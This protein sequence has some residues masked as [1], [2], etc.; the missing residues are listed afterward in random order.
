[1]SAG[2]EIAL[3]GES[4][5]V[6][7]LRSLLGKRVPFAESKRG[8]FGWL[9]QAVAENE[10]EHTKLVAS[11]MHRTA[12]E[13]GSFS[14]GTSTAWQSGEAGWISVPTLANELGLSAT[15][16][17]RLSETMGFHKRQF[18]VARARYRA[19]SPKQTEMMRQALRSSLSRSEAAAALGVSRDTFNAFVAA[20]YIAIFARPGVGLN[21]DR[22][23]SEDVAAL[24]VRLLRDTELISEMPDRYLRLAD[25]R[26]TCK[27]DPALS[28]KECL[29]R[30][31]PLRWRVGPTAGDVLI[32]NPH[33]ASPDNMEAARAALHTL[34]GLSFYQAATIL[35][36]N[37]GVIEGLVEMKQ[38]RMCSETRGWRRIDPATVEAFGLRYASPEIYSGQGDCRTKIGQLGSKLVKLGI[39]NLLVERSDGSR[40]YVIDRSSAATVL[41]LAHDPDDPDIDGLVPLEAEMLRAIGALGNFKLVGRARGI[42]L[43]S[44]AGQLTIR[45]RFRPEQSAIEVVL[46][47]GA[48]SKKNIESILFRENGLQL[49]EVDGRFE[50][51]D[52]I[53]A[54]TLTSASMRSILVARILAATERLRSTFSFMRNT[55]SPSDGLHVQT[56]EL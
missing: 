46:T 7:L 11:L 15:A 55:R 40:S 34:P 2:F 31:M 32:A 23:R 44:S 14:R 54:E 43:C 1:M 9:T 22:F 3:G 6:E 53:T 48:G 16:V 5:L 20:G 52:I 45:I 36:C 17:R 29:T 49:R 13:Q 47:R 39:A 21:R 19:F 35:G 51:V 42:T 24:A 27:T 28:V 33:P 30:D 10:G 26:R 38:L 12:V 4:A 37:I 50:I 8:P 25:L 18:G 56:S 41:S